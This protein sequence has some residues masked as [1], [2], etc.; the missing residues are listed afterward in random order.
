MNFSHGMDSPH[1]L[2]NFDSIIVIGN[3]LHHVDNLPQIFKK[4]VKKNW[5]RIEPLANN[6]SAKKLQHF[7]ELQKID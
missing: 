1:L 5:Q 7:E 2:G 4:I 3:N 6:F